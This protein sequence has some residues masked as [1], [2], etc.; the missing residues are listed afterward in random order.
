MQVEGVGVSGNRRHGGAMNKEITALA[1]V[2]VCTD[3]TIAIFLFMYFP[4]LSSP[5]L[6]Y[7]GECSGFKDVPSPSEDMSHILTPGTCEYELI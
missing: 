1:I 3:Y 2:C 5:L 4:F 6:L 7:V